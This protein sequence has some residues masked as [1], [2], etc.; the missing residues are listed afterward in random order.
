M[1]KFSEYIRLQEADGGLGQVAGIGDDDEN[2]YVK[3][4]IKDLI[5]KAQ[6]Y[7]VRDIP[8]TTLLPLLQGRIEDPTQTQARASQSEL[9]YPIIVFYS[10]D[11]RKIFAI[12]DG[13]HRVQKAAGMELK[14]IQ[15]HVIPKE[16]MAEFA[17]QPTQS[18][19]Q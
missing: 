11:S 9:K 3:F 1:M 4:A 8:M 7:P 16:D 17:V 14:T 2:F 10:N 5:A 6:Q 12:G 19:Q 13:T 18:R 15:A